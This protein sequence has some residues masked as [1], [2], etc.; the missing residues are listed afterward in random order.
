MSRASRRPAS[1]PVLGGVAELLRDADRPDAW[2]LLVDGVPQSHVDLAD[3]AYLAF[4]Y[5][6]RLGHAVDLVAK[7]GRPVDAVHLGGGALTLARYVATTR[8]GSRQRVMEL[9]GPL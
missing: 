8:P 9:D 1:W 3:P 6:R 2:M 5:V 7:T 4:E